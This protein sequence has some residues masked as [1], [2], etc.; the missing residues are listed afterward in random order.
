MYNYGYNCAIEI[1]KNEFYDFKYQTYWIDP[2][3][4]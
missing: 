4:Q 2:N 1:S 3:M